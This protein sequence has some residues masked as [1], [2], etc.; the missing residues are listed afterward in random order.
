M[1]TCRFSLARTPQSGCNRACS[2]HSWTFLPPDS[3]ALLLHF[4]SSSLVLGITTYHRIGGG[5][6]TSALHYISDQMQTHS[7]MERN[8]STTTLAIVVTTLHGLFHLSHN[9]G[10]L[11]WLVLSKNIALTTMKK[12]CT[13][14]FH[15]SGLRC[16]QPRNRAPAAS[17]SGSFFLFYN[18]NWSNVFFLRFFSS[19]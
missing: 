19:F 17:C 6:D 8:P 9:S 1:S 3:C 12:Y 13:E 4:P 5:H 18:R 11:Y 14:S 16:S 10:R 7:W 2:H 15:K